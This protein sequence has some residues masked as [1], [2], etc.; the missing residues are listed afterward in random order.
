MKAA[1]YT[2]FGPPEVLQITE[3]ETPQPKENE[4]LIRIHASTVE[5]EDPG[6]RKSPGLNG[7]LKP[8]HRILGMELAGKIEAVGGAVSRFKPGDRIFGNTGLG[9][10]SY[11]EYICLPEN[12][13]LAVKPQNL[14]YAEAAASTNGALTAIPFLR[15]KAQVRPGQS[16]LINGA[17]GTVGSAA[18]QIAK[19]F[20]A[21]VTAVCSTANMA[22]VGALGADRV[23]DYSQ[24]DFIELNRSEG[25]RFDII[26]D[27]AGKTAFRHCVPILQ[28][29]GIFMSTVPTPAIMVQTLWTRFFGRSRQVKFAA[30][31]L[32]APAKKAVDLELLRQIIEAGHF[33][34]R[35]DCSFPLEQIADAHRHIE[36][37]RKN[38]TVVV[39][40]GL[41]E[42]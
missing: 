16:I 21:D 23:I 14:S 31:G 19:Y 10:G 1:V 12:G 20:G 22:A 13:A 8:K 29:E 18:V 24:D 38:G 42:Q 6:M 40:L 5:K 4:V 25:R 28:P 11:A 7:I 30:T 36:S 37:G 35:I 32:R 26:F 9:L 3:I 41:A 17:S 15:D 27:V 2:K 33:R 34:P 39:T